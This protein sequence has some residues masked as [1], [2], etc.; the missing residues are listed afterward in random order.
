VPVP[1]NSI[2]TGARYWAVPSLL[3]WSAAA[4]IAG[5]PRVGDAGA[6]SGRGWARQG[7][8]LWLAL[9]VAADFVALNPGRDSGPFWSDQVAAG[10]RSCAAGAAG[11]TLTTPPD[12]LWIVV[13]PCSLLRG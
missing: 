10:A 5:A 1:G 12:P 3:L 9:L 6:S 8:L 7:I 4:L 13:V 2:E 11:A